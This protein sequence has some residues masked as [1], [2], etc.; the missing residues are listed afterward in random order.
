MGPLSLFTCSSKKR[1]IQYYSL[2]DMVRN[3]CETSFKLNVY[4]IQLEQTKNLLMTNE[5]SYLLNNHPITTNNRR[6]NI[7]PKHQANTETWFQKICTLGG[8]STNVK[9]NTHPFDK[10]LLLEEKYK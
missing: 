2:Y 5:N 4:N 10:G 3:L 8:N 1:I 6:L 9:S 7:K